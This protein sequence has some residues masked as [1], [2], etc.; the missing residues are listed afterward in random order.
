MLLLVVFAAAN[1]LSY[2]VFI[3]FFITYNIIRLLYVGK[4]I[5]FVIR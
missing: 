1:N 2:I 5:L 4:Y 3:L